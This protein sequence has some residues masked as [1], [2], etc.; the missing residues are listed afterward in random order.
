MPEPSFQPKRVLITG[1]AGF[2][3][4]A[5]VRMVL[6]RLPGTDI[7]NL[8]CLTYAASLSGLEE[9]LEHPQHHFVRGDITDRDAVRRAMDGCDAVINVA[10]ES[11]VDRSIADSSPFIRTNVVG[12]Q[13]LLDTARELK[14]A[15]YLQVSTDEVYGSLSLDPGEPAFKETTPLNPSS[16]YAASKAAADLLVL[17]YGHTFGFPGMITRCSNNFGPRQFP[18]KVIPL[19]TINLMQGKR[20]PL[21][22]DGLNVRDWIHVDDHC[23]AIIAALQRGEPGGVY[24]VGASNEHPNVELTHMLLN[25]TGRDASFIEPVTDRLGHD[26]RYAIDSTWTR[27]SLGWQATSSQWPAALNETVQ[28]YRDHQPWWESILS[29]AYRDEN[30]RLAELVGT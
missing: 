23:A 3:G 25:L 2:I 1:G 9:V 26:R 20:V 11:H 14:V 6:D 18:E 27:Q 28:W 7:V 5:L 29:G 13:T 22:G 4:S 21:Y 15:R 30:E 24:N 19:F 12:T 10:A 17:A 8:D 16:P